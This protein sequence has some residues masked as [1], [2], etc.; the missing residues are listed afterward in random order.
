L[1]LLTRASSQL[2]PYFSRIRYTSQQKK[3][4]FRDR[5]GVLYG[6]ALAFFVF[7]KIPLIGVLIYGIAEAST[8][9]LITKI[10]EPPP[11]PGEAE[12]FKKTDVR[13]VNKHEFLQLPLDGMDKFNIIEKS[14]SSGR[15]DPPLRQQ[16]T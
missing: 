2:E 6:F 10:T 14:K 4:W 13:W 8:A 1:S 12:E 9:Y 5:E 15:Q 11:P 16:F 7:L 3:A